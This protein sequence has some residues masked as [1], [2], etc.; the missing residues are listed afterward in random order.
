MVLLN[1]LSPGMWKN[2]TNAGSLGA[3]RLPVGGSNS[4]LVQSITEI[5]GEDFRNG[6]VVSFE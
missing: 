4:P 3:S 1:S 2:R 5:A 6:A